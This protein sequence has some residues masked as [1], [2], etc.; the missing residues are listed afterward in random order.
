VD[1]TSKSSCNHYPVVD[2]RTAR[3]RAQAPN[4]S[5]MMANALAKYGSAPST[6]LI[7]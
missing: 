1:R 4:K 7:I 2:S 3:I 6:F 5:E